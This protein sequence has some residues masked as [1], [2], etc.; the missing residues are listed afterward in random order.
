VIVVV[1]AEQIITMISKPFK[2]GDAVKTSTTV[3]E[4]VEW[5]CR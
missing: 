2:N 5:R 4:M 1:I 3:E